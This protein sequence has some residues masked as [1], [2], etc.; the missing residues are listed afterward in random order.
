[1]SDFL[2]HELHLYGTH[3]GCEHAVCGAC[4]VLLDGRLARSC[5]TLAAQA[6]GS[7]I[8]TI[9]GLAVDDG[10]EPLRQAFSR[11]GALQCGFCMPG[12]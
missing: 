4:T 2:R 1:M 12:I 7:E 3:V 11:H 5:S 8:T 6:E 10:L 9:E